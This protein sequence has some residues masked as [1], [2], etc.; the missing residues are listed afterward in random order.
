MLTVSVEIT[1]EIILSVSEEASEVVS[2]PVISE[3]TEGF[4]P[5]SSIASTLKDWAAS[6]SMVSSS[7]D[8]SSCREL[9]YCSSRSWKRSSVGSVVE[10]GGGVEDEE[11]ESLSSSE[12]QSSDQFSDHSL[13]S[14]SH[15]SLSWGDEYKLV[16]C[17]RWVE[18]VV[19]E[20][21]RR[22]G[23]AYHLEDKASRMLL[24]FEGK[25]V[26]RGKQNEMRALEIFGPILSA[27]FQLQ[28]MNFLTSSQCAGKS[29]NITRRVIWQR[30]QQRCPIPGQ[31]PWRL[32]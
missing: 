29:P 32:E 28:A 21:R 11:E 9:K 12:D 17:G 14:S 2:L 1:E 16:G 31:L 18:G 3:T 7:E 8:W 20:G 24:E 23:K 4:N 5:A 19:K 25:R 13:D 22:V 15:S 30:Q 26:R 27:D 6:F 10:D